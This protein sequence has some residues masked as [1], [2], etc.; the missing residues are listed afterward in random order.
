[1]HQAGGDVA[2][3]GVPGEA[4]VA[5]DQVA[6]HHPARQEH[7]AIGDDRACERRRHA[8][9]ARLT[10]SDQGFIAQGNAV[11]ED[12]Q[13]E[14]EVVVE[15]VPHQHRVDGT[16]PG[17][18]RAM[19]DVDLASADGQGFGVESVIEAHV[20][21]R[22]P[23]SEGSARSPQGPRVR[24]PLRVLVDEVVV[25]TLVVLPASDRY[26]QQDAQRRMEGDQA[27]GDRL[28]GAPPRP[29]AALGDRASAGSACR[30]RS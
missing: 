15:A 23:R 18:E 19:A 22:R 28:G 21:E 17:R 8:A 7:Q 14:V 6:Q 20:E 29:G 25:G 26:G 4:V 27:R 9:S 30:A 10:R 12:I 16:V 3:M 1:M 13:L 24:Q 2:G 11:D 5:R